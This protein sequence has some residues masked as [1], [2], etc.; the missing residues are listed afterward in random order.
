VSGVDGR[1]YLRARW[2]VE[3]EQPVEIC[4]EGVK[5][6]FQPQ[7]T[8]VELTYGPPCIR[9]FGV[10]LGST[11]KVEAMFSDARARPLTSAPP[12]VLVLLD[13][14]RKLLN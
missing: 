11:E 1:T 10:R 12:F 5:L 7:W 6:R 9:V 4:H 13:R 14:T 8:E 2:N 3:A